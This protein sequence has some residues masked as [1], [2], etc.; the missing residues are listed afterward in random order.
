VALPLLELLT[1]HLTAFKREAR[2]SCC[3]SRCRL[4][5]P[6]FLYLRFSM[7]A[8]PAG[9][10]PLLALLQAGVHSEALCGPAATHA[11]LILHAM[12]LLLLRWLERHPQMVS[13]RKAGK[14]L[15]V[16][17]LATA[18]P[19]EADPGQDLLLKIPE[20]ATQHFARG[21][22]TG[23]PAAVFDEN[24]PLDGRPLRGS[25][26][27]A[28]HSR[29]PTQRLTAW[30]RSLRSHGAGPRL[31]RWPLRTTSRGTGCPATC[32]Y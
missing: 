3:A 30:A 14:G 32:R 29:Q 5:Y 7:Q 25:S 18:C 22:P 19:L 10:A 24:V 11:P 8:G 9:C 21:T 2:P 6:R 23:P 27:A 26:S 1:A 17:H 16:M 15:Q 20:R 28:G 12:S 31:P 4:S 13:D